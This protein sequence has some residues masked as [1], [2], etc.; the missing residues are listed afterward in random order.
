MSTPL[1]G[2]KVLDMTHFQ[3]GPSA[4]QLLAWLGADV[5][6]IEEPIIG[7]K[8]RIEMSTDNDEDSFYFRI[9]NSNKKSICI[10]IKSPIGLNILKK[11]IYASDVLVENFAP[12]YME[13]LGLN[14]E[15][16]KIINPKIIYASIKGYGSNGINSKYKSFEG[17]AQA[18]SGIMGTNGETNKEP[19][20]VSAGVSDSGSG[21]HC[22]IGILSALINRS[23]THK[24]DFID[25]SMQDTSLN[26][27]RMK[28]INTLNSDIPEP[29]I[30]N[31]L[32]GQPSLFSCYPGGYYDYVYIC[33]GG[34][35]WESILAIIGRSDLIFDKRFDSELSRTKHFLEIKNVIEEWTIK[36]SKFEIMDTFNNAGIPCSAVYSTNEIIND[37]HLK[38]RKMIVDVD[39]S[40]INNTYKQI[41]SPINMDSFKMNITRH[42]GLGEHSAEL[43][44]EILGFDDEYISKLRN[45][46]IIN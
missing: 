36:H 31:I 14:Y 33:I 44:K 26:L 21:L 9:F 17:V 12:G 23:K 6:K 1:E 20:I 16:L 30:G 8:A 11:L 32:R 45:L 5:I 43:L 7:D 24:G 40:N 13:K 25:I 46:N 38:S 29:R 37:I 27:N 22:V 15:N 39:S 2:I 4:T 3:S 18:A 41:G 10:D 19:Q 34:E 42:P 35:S 28:M